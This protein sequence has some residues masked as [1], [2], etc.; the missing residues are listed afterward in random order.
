MTYEPTIAEGLFLPA[1]PHCDWLGEPTANSL[2]ALG[3]SDRHQ[4][5][6]HRRPQGQ[7]ALPLEDLEP[8]TPFAAAVAERDRALL[9]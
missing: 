8:L 9:S 2:T 5:T 7:L 4:A 1:C 6:E 3:R